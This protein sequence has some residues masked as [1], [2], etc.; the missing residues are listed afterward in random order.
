[1]GSPLRNGGAISKGSIMNGKQFAGSTYIEHAKSYEKEYA[2]HHQ[3]Q[4][5][6][7]AKH[8]WSTEPNET[9]LTEAELDYFFWK[10]LVHLGWRKS[11]NSPSD[12]YQLMLVC[13]ECDK[14]ILSQQSHTTTLAKAR[15]MGDKVKVNADKQDHKARCKP[16]EYDED[17]NLIEAVSEATPEGLPDNPVIGDTY[18][19][20]ATQEWFLFNGETWGR[21]SGVTASRLGSGST[22]TAPAMPTGVSISPGA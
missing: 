11:Y 21:I 14:A 6:K 9:P 1:M 7:M 10:T 19:N 17:G 12:S 22:I 2:K 18:F 3:K 16:L 4:D 15:K 5:Q 8:Q 13:T 20:P